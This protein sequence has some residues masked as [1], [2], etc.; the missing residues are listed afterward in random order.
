MKQDDPSIVSLAIGDGAND[1]AMILQADIGVGIFGKEGNRSV[2]SSDFAIA[3]FRFLWVLLF[4]HG[5][6]NYKR[7]SMMLNYYFYKNFVY[8]FMQILYSFNNGFS[9]KSVFPEAFL[10]LYNL[11]FTALPIQWYA[12]SEIDVYPS[13]LR[14]SVNYRS[15]I[16]SL[17]FPGQRNLQ[18]NYFIT[19]LWLTVGFV[20][21]LTIYLIPF[22]G[23]H[24]KI[25][26][27]DG[28]VCED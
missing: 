5:R 16:P 20:Q 15:F 14:D 6:W 24:G 19:V 18:Y 13:D 25:L 8:T 4:K 10:T 22:Y 11:V 26:N 7:F 23:L 21:S 17:Y 2:D 27:V 12:V 1:V 28:N 9:M 3:E